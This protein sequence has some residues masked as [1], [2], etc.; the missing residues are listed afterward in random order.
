[1]ISE[2]LLELE[3]LSRAAAGV[4]DDVLIIS[5]DLQSLSQR[6]GVINGFMM[7]DDEDVGERDAVDS[8]PPFGGAAGGVMRDP[9]R[10]IPDDG[11]RR[12][13]LKLEFREFPVVDDDPPVGV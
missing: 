12:T 8:P 2:E 3:S 10:E 13:R 11:S 1:M 4:V 7:F 6:S 5:A 9:F